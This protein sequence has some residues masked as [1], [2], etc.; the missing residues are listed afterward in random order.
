M[1]SRPYPYIV[2]AVLASIIAY[3]L[4]RASDEEKILAILHEMRT[5]AEISEPESGISQAATARQLS[6]YFDELTIYDLTNAGYRIVE[7]SSRQE[8][9]RQILKIRSM[10]SMLKLS[11]QNPMVNIDGNR[12][13][14]ELLGSALGSSRNVQGQFLEIH[15]VEISLAGC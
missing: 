12:A 13:K 3:I 11:M 4:L 8:L 5:L 1:L 2:L 14:V 10:L 15:R 6:R 7:I 9:A